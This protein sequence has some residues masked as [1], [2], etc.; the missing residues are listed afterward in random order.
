MN[1]IPVTVTEEVHSGN[2]PRS[3][4]YLCD[5]ER[6]LSSFAG[7]YRGKVKALYIDPPFGT[8]KAFTCR[9]PIGEEGW[10][11]KGSR[12]IQ[13]EAFSD[14]A[15][16]GPYIAKMRS[17]LGSA[18]DLLR[19]DALVFVHVDSRVSAYV[20]LLLDELFGE[21]GFRSEIIWA[22]NSGGRTT[23]TF[24][25]KH[26]VIYMYSVSRS[27]G[28]YP[29]Q[30]MTLPAQPRSNHMRKH[31]DPD[32]RTYRSIRSNGKVYTYYDDEPVM[33]SDVWTDIS[34]LQQKDPERTGYDTQKPLALLRRIWGASSRNDDTVCDLY[35]GSCTSMDAASSMGRAFVGT[36]I[37]PV[38]A[39]I[40]RRRMEGREYELVLPLQQQGCG[41]QWEVIQGIG[42]YHVTLTGFAGEVCGARG[43]DAVAGWSC[44]YFEDGRYTVLAQAMRDTRTPALPEELR[45]PM[46]SARPAAAVYDIRGGMACCVFGDI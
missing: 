43:M 13:L 10:K 42:Y 23:K 7:Q 6:F 31:V 29:E 41:A 38:A 39:N 28:F 2:G 34:H 45:L 14:S 16:K 1:S 20:R 3:S 33:P 25:R 46:Y 27:Y 4:L 21:E 26:D 15:D 32:G 9:V 17:V 5:N 30:I 36:E 22:Y 8:G 40:A 12:S 35:C 44:G 37:N 11:K 18:R 24:S 19:D